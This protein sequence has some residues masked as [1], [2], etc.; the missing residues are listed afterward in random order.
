MTLL[1]KDCAMQTG[2]LEAR[3]EEHRKIQACG[4]ATIEDTVRRTD[5]LTVISERRWGF[6]VL[7]AFG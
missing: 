6:C 1:E 2:L 4:H 3:G 7:K 5:L